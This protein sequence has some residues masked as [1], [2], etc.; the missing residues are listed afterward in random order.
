MPKFKGPSFQGHLS[1]YIRKKLDTRAGEFAATFIVDANGRP[2][3]LKIIQGISTKFDAEYVKAFNASKGMW[4]PAQHNGRPVK[5][6]MSQ[7][8]K[9]FTSAQAMPSYF[10]GRKADAAYQGKDYELALYYYDKALE[11]RDDDIDHLYKRGIC[12]QMLG[13]IKGACEDWNKIKALGKNVADELLLKY[14]K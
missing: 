13:N 9:Y 12:K 1:D 14:C 4:I 10:E 11:A 6:L 5:V 8:M 3:S 2:D 7:T